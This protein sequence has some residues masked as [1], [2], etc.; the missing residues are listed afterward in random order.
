[1][2]ALAHGGKPMRNEEDGDVVAKVVHRFHHRL[3]GEVVQRAGGFIQ[4]QHL[5]VVVERSGNANALALPAREAHAALAHGGGVA[6][7]QVVDHK[8][9]QV[10]DFGRAGVQKIDPSPITLNEPRGVRQYI[11]GARRSFELAI[12][13]HPHEKLPT[14]F[15]GCKLWPGSVEGS[16]RLGRFF[17]WR[18]QLI[19]IALFKP[20]QNLGQMPDG[21]A[22]FVHG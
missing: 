18:L 2:V 5:R 7:R 19:A 1:L 22:T 3:F 8:F 12:R 14:G 10:G 20:V 6:L 16:N 9:M 21:D 13:G 4:N 11:D 15:L 17:Q